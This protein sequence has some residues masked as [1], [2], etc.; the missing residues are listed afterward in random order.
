[1]S[2]IARIRPMKLK[3]RPGIL[4]RT[5]YDPFFNEQLKAMVPRADRWF[6]DHAKGWWIAEAHADVIRHLIRECHGGLEIT[7]EHGE[8]I[9]ETA[10]GERIH[11]ESLL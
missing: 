2:K 6:N 7:D 11:Q 4:V 10:D 8:S 3:G 5:P 9:I 1:M